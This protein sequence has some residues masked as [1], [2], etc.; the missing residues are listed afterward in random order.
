MTGYKT[1]PELLARL[2]K[3][4]KAQLSA[5]TLRKQKVSFIMGSL[6]EESTI[7]RERVEE[8]LDKLEGYAA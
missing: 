2:E 8:V 3:A 4:A 7:T 1:D 6:G 5:K